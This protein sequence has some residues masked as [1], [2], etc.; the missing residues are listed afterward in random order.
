MDKRYFRSRPQ[1]RTMRGL[2]IVELL[3]TVGIVA[4][5]GSVTYSAH[6]SYVKRTRLPAALTQLEVLALRMEQEYSGSH[7]YGSSGCSV[8]PKQVAGFHISCELVDNGQ[9][10]IATATGH[11]PLAGYS[12]TVDQA[13][14]RSTAA[15]PKGL[16]RDACWSMTGGECL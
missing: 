4:I 9:G 2:T 16:P 5:L 6:A 7:S 14:R 12:F 10:F 1:R 15:H 11:G 13:G 8:L 3:V